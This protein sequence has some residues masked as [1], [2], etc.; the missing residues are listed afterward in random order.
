MIKGILLYVI[1][2][3]K[4]DNRTKCIQDRVKWR[5]VVEK[6]KTFNDDDDDDDD[7]DDDDDD[8]DGGGGGGEGEGGG[9]RGGWGGGDN[10]DDD[11]HSQ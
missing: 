3:G 5:E 9:G 4:F 6:A 11:W 8:D 7:G 1:H 10:D 2:S